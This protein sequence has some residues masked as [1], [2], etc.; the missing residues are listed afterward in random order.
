MIPLKLNMSI[1]VIIRTI[2]LLWILRLLFFYFTFEIKVLCYT[3]GK[4]NDRRIQI[5]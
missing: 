4:E 3:K 5:A 2:L 1:A